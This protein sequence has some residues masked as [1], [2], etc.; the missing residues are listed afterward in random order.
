MRNHLLQDDRCV[1]TAPRKAL[2]PE[3]DDFMA[4]LDRMV[5]ENIHERGKEV[6]KPPA[7]DIAIPWQ[8]KASLK[9]PSG[10]KSIL[11]H[12]SCFLHQSSMW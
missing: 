1:V 10:P 5:A 2:C 4:A 9:K 7:V 8:V 11:F 12:P 3:D 6:S